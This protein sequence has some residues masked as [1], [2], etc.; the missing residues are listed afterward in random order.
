MG[1]TASVDYTV[2]PRL[3]PN[4]SLITYIKQPLR[5]WV[6]AVMYGAKLPL[7]ADLAGDHSD[8]NAASHG[9]RTRNVAAGLIARHCLRRA[10]GTGAFAISLREVRDE[11]PSTPG[12]DRVTGPLNDSER[13]TSNSPTKKVAEVSK[14]SVGS[15]RVEGLIREEII[16][17][18]MRPGLGAGRGRVVCAGRGRT[19][20][21]FHQP[22]REH[23]AGV[24]VDPLIEQRSNFL[25]KVGGMTEP[26]EFVGLERCSGSGQKEFPRRL[27]LVTGHR[28]LLGD[29]NST[30]TIDETVVNINL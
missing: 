20:A 15:R 23:R 25:T 8:R 26:R 19:L 28:T 22:T 5:K 4:L 13:E 1:A 12:R 3:S 21:L 7:Q 6:E 17:R 16:G 30:V 24:F 29:R 2:M 11:H 10:S 27:C 9:R 18:G 14:N